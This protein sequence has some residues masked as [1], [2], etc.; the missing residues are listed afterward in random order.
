[1][2]FHL[3][4]FQIKFDALGNSNHCHEQEALVDV[5]HMFKPLLLYMSRLSRF[6]ILET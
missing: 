4:L 5:Y 6:E 3:E 2:A 1:M